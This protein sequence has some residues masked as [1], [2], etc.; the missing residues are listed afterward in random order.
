MVHPDSCSGIPLIFAEP[1]G[2]PRRRLVVFLSGFGGGKSRVR[3]RIESLAE[4]G[5]HAVSF[6]PYQHE[7]RRIES[8][9]ELSRR[10]HSNIRQH[11]W[12]IL[13]RTIE[14]VPRVIDWGLER[15]DVDPAGVG[16][17]GISMGGDIALAVAGIDH[18]VTAVACGIATPD[19]LR[20][21]TCQDV[22]HPDRDALLWF[23][24]YNPLNHP[25]RYPHQPAIAIECGAE[26]AMVPPT[27]ALIFEQLL[28]GLYGTHRDRI[29]VTLHAGTGHHYPEAMWDANREWFKQ[30]LPPTR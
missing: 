30:H 8:Q 24:K 10:I 14:E 17:G 13:G 15:F 19:W 26:D 5:F 25:D 18:R 29:R 9:E 28:A 6:D 23:E 20:P 7:D 1:S 3:G 21:G 27:S 16:V 12:P 11:F 4:A 22:G 2:P